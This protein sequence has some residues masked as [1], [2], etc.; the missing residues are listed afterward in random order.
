[1][2]AISIG[3]ILDISSRFLSGDTG[4]YGLFAIVLPTI[5]TPLTARSILTDTGKK[6]IQHAV[7]GIGFI[8]SSWR[9]D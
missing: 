7:E 9:K 2:L 3:L 1:M 4:A 6:A 8:P 5:L